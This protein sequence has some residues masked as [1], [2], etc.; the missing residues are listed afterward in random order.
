M[1]MVFGLITRAAAAIA[2]IFL[3]VLGTVPVRAA[4]QPVLVFAAAS[5]TNVLQ[6]IGRDF[7]A[8]RGTKISFSFAASMTLARQIAASSGADI[9]AAADEE[10]M[11]YLDARG[12]IARASRKDLLRNTLVL[13]APAGSNL[14]L[15]I[16]ERFGLAR[17]LGGGRLAMANPDAVPAGRY[18]RAALQAL[19]VWDGVANRLAPAEDVRA[20][21]AYVARGEA[22]LGIV[23]ATDARVESKVR[24]VATFP[25]NSHDSIVYPVALTRDAKPAAARFLEYLSGPEARAMFVRAGFA[26]VER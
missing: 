22:P 24:V 6:N 20:A 2:A 15:T 3:S 25:A 12:L 26:P 10:S 8:K 14:R 4:E 18:G 9:F 16:G 19:G 11:D 13:I 1:T 23:Y 5:L 7:E 21:L 17:A